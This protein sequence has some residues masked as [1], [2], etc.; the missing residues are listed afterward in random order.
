MAVFALVGIFSA[1]LLPARHELRDEMQRKLIERAGAMLHPLT[2]QSFA[3]QSPDASATDTLRAVLKSAEQPGLLAMAVF[4][5]DGALVQAVPASLPFVDLPPADFLELT[6]LEPI[7]RY[8]PDFRPHNTFGPDD[9]PLEGTP[10][11]EVLL[12]L[13][14]TGETRLAGI[15][16]CWI[17]ARPLT[18]DLAAIDTRIRQQTATTLALAAALIGLVVSLATWRL[19]L[20][21]R[22]IAERNERLLR[23]NLELS[24]A[25]KASVLGQITSH[26]LHGLQTPVAGLRAVMATRNRDADS[27][28]WQTAADYTTRLQQMIEQTVTMLG[29]R[30]ARV[31]YDLTAA[32]FAALLRE[33]HAATARARGVALTVSA[34]ADSA[35]L[36]SHRGHLLALAVGNLVENALEASPR[37]STVRV[38]LGADPSA[39]RLTIADA[40]PGLP[41]AVREHLFLP[42][43]STKPG[44]TGLGLAISHL[45]ARQIGAELSLRETGPC[46]TC[47]E[48]TLLLQADSPAS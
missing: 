22:A 17:D 21:Q 37:H 35:P 11:L 29:E 1:L 28:D 19:T 5:G 46:G 8:Q 30:E 18:E 31:A 2:L 44:G 42:G 39:W 27:D 43:R 15:V 10:V 3:A 36:A 6:R 40:G 41:D 38:T 47:F 9:T 34:P 45:L 13:H 24:L 20:A 23:T 7:S 4:D 33:R 25:A 26:L 12:P 14:R 16:Q 32:E 48:I